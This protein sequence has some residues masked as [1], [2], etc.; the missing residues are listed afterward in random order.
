M[1]I[2]TVNGRVLPEDLGLTYIHEHLKADLSAHKGDPDTCYDD[3][4]GVIAELKDLRHK[5]LGAIV[6][7]TNWGMG[8]D[9]TA[10]I[11][12]AEQTG[13]KVIPSTGVYKEP[14]LPSWVHTCTEKELAAKMIGEIV[15]GIGESGIQAH[16][17][18]EV[19]TSAE[20]I[21]PLERKALR[22]AA[23]AHCETGHPLYT[24]TT[25]GRLGLEQ[26]KLLKEMSVNLCKVVIG[27]TDLSSDP[28]IHLRLASSGCYLGFDTVGKD[29]YQEDTVRAQ[30]IKELVSRGFHEQ[31][32]LSQ[33]LTRKSHLR[34]RGGI[35]YGYLLEN[36]LPLLLE[37]GV[38][39]RYIDAMLRDNPARLLAVEG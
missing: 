3:L 29:K 38:E 18:G 9:L 19:G 39:Q 11:Q 20:A 37:K 15:Q 33:D 23:R 1:Y 6:E 34:A 30:R 27:H 22:A 7:A 8:R 13:I 16:V 4:P 2:Q 12:V 35:G 14:F 24:H 31:I 28:E 21:T 25:L 17:I 32:V 5:G 26:V 10:M 36:F